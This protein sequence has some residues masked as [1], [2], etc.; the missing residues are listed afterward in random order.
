MRFDTLAPCHDPSCNASTVLSAHKVALEGVA[1]RQPQASRW[2][3]DWTGGVPPW[4][5]AIYN[6]GCKTSYVDGPLKTNTEKCCFALLFE[7]FHIALAFYICL[8]LCD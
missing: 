6:S 7:L 1:M 3:N 2:L 8:F 4:P 5:K